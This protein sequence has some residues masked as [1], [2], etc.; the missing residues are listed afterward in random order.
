MKQPLKQ[1]LQHHLNQQCLS[2]KQLQQL[3]AIQQTQPRKKS[4]LNDAWFKQSI[5]ASLLFLLISSLFILRPAY[6]STQSIEQRIAEEVVGNHLK[7]KPLEVSTNTIDDIKKYFKHLNF[8]PIS[9]SFLT[10]SNQSLIGGRYCSIQGITAVQLRL[11]N[12][13]TGQVQSL[14]ETEYDKN[15]FKKLSVSVDAK[16]PLTI[17]S[18]GM[19][20]HI[21]VEKD[22]LFALTE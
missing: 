6:F 4:I 1:S 3:H 5:V 20:V 12:N 9:P 14:Y 18:S 13:T 21:W 17:Y 15:I 19:K 2:A 10:A 11:V 16:K 8:L 7:L 22:I